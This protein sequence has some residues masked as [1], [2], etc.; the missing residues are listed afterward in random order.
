VTSVS[1]IIPTH[2]RASLVERA[3]DSV[4]KQSYL[5][6]EII[7]V[8]DG[9]TDGTRERIMTIFPDVTYLYQE[10]KGV[11]AAR[12]KGIEL[13][14]G[15][16]I[17]FLDSDDE[18]LPN[19]LGNQID[20][21]NNHLSVKI[22]HTNEIWL[23]NGKRIKQL[24]KHKKQGG[25]IFKWCLPLCVIS[26]SSAMIHKAVFDNVGLFD[27][28]L[29]ACED[30][31][32]WLRIS[33]QYQVHYLEE[34]LII[35]HGGHADQLSRKHWGMDRFR[36]RALENIVLSNIL[37][38]DDQEAAMRMLLEKIDIFSAGAQKRGNH[39]MVLAYQFM[40]EKYVA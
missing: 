1:V 8:D 10:N 6:Q 20:A 17:A 37:S 33:A 22:V 18:W 39:E 35:K 23:R 7:V 40:K 12:N 21:V 13:A 31:D 28:T 5:P 16:W 30:Y 27:T 29:P 19:K 15:K 26:P 4:Y 24:K 9:S 34:P 32:M 11:S 2:N 38:T 36:I 25:H 14:K 3:L